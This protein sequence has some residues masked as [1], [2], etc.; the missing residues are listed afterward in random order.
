MGVQRDLGARGAGVG[1]VCSAAVYDELFAHVRALLRSG[2]SCPDVQR[3][4][5]ASFQR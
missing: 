5:D 2:A 4:L 1:H 3:A